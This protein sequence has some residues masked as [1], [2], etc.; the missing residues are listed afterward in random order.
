MFRLN[1]AFVLTALIT[2]NAHA[3]TVFANQPGFPDKPTFLSAVG[4]E[5]FDIGFSDATDMLVD[6]GMFDPL[7]TFGSPT[8]GEPS[9]VF[10]S[11]W[12]SAITDVG[13]EIDPSDGS[14]LTPGTTGPIDAV[15][16]SSVGAFSLDLTGQTA[17][18]TVSVFD[19]S[20]ILVMSFLTPSPSGFL[21]VIHSPGIKRVLF[22]NA[23][24]RIALDEMQ[25]FTVVPLPPAF[26]LMIPA[27]AIIRLTSIARRSGRAS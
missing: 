15:F 2:W 24:E 13:T 4:P 6:G 25:A 14:N 17:A 10:W 1:I 8:G 26:V 20:D 3:L 9:K 19:S 18:T 23:V 21:G 7:V 16:T 22:E 12:S 5:L 11:S 27:M